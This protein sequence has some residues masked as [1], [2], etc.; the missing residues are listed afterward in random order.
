LKS[1]RGGEEATMS[2]SHCCGQ[3][4]RAAWSTLIFDGPARDWLAVDWAYSGQKFETLGYEYV[5]KFVG[6]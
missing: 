2:S 4:Q 6:K 1:L 3:E 5:E